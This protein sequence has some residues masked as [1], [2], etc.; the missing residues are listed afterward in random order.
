LDERTSPRLLCREDQSSRPAAEVRA[1][2]LA[3]NLALRLTGEALEAL[4][5]I[6][7]CAAPLKGVVLLS[8]WPELQGHRDLADVD[9]LVAPEEFVMAVQALRVQGFEPTSYTFHGT[10]L[11]HSD[12]PLS[13]DLHHRLFGPHLFDMPTAAVLARAQRDDTSFGAP[14]MRLC[15]ADLF[16]HIVGHAVKSRMRPEDV[17]AV[18]DIRWLLQTLA[19]HPTEYA[20][21]LRHLGLHRAAA[22]VLGARAYRKE[23]LAHEIVERLGLDVH[24]RTAIRAAGVWPTAYWT[25]HVLNPRPMQR[26]LSFSAQVREDLGW[27][28]RR[29]S[30]SWA[31]G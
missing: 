24:D 9:L 10:T 27:R 13:I 7:I 1:Q 22:Y 28:V 29:W 15:D 11:V 30:S 12:W 31:R 21:H 16:A 23:P 25:P 3:A 26:A 6:G 8:R 18:D 20:N 14:S 5:R 19:I 2:E 4:G 17:R